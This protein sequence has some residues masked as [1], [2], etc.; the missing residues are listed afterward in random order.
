M[1]PGCTSR[2]QP[3]R[4]SFNKPF[5]DVIRQQFEEHLEEN[6]QRYTEGKITLKASRDTNCQQLMK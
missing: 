2:V 5:K 1:S 6:L 3:L 4:V